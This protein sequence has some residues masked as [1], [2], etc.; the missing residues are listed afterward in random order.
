MI[1]S[2]KHKIIFIKPRKVAGTSFEIALSK[3]L[4]DDDIITPVS[5]ED[6]R[7][8]RKLGFTG[9]RGFSFG[10][11]KYFGKK[12][13]K[14]ISLF[15][16][17]LPHK[18]YNHIS[19]PQIKRRLDAAV[20]RDYRK[21][22][23]VRNP[24]E[25]AVSIFFWKNTKSWKQPNLAEFTSYFMKNKYLLEI[26]YPNYMVGGK[27]VIDTYIRYENFEEDILKL[28]REVPSLAGLWDTFKD[29][30]AKADT[31]DKSRTTAE[32]FR[33]NPEVNA[34]VEKMNRWEIEKFSYHL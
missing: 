18:Y 28:E 6:E 13:T 24:W 29:I 16:L 31:R 5:R 34:L 2:H 27:D 11:A 1:V 12:P 7:I 10:F 23:I 8:R 22:S 3:Y 26:N 15:G 30:N 19:A 9:P 20:W 4:A 32:I 25:R 17:R 21:V 33:N 14:R